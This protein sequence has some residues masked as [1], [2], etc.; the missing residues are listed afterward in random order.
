MVRP[1]DPNRIFEFVADDAYKLDYLDTAIIGLTMNGYLVYDYEKIIQH[2]MSNGLSR[3]D[4]IDYTDFNVIGLA[5]EFANWIIIR[6]NN[7]IL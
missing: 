3:E 1:L 7:D 2:F 4:A 5:G 6:Q